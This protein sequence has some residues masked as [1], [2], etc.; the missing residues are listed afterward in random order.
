ML[1]RHVMLALP[2]IESVP[3]HVLDRVGRITRG[4]G[5][6]LELFH[7]VHNS[8]LTGRAMPGAA[9]DDLVRVRMEE[10]HRRLE[11]IADTLRDQQIDVHASVRAD[12]PV[13][14]AIIRQVLHHGSNLLIVP[15][16]RLGHAG[17]SR[18]LTYTDSRLIE[19]CPCPL[20][21]LK[22]NQAYA[23]GPIVAA[24]DPSHAHDKPAALDESIIA[25]A[26][27]LSSALSQAP[28][29]LYHAVP[30]LTEPAMRPGNGE[31]SEAPLSAERQKVHWVGREH[32]VRKLA[33]RHQLSERS[34]YVELGRI[35]A[36][37][38]TYSREVRA[39]AVVMGAISRSYPQRVLFGYTAEKVLDALDSDV[40]IVKPKG[41]RSPVHRRP[42]PTPQRA[43][44]QG[45]GALRHMAEREE[46]AT[47]WGWRR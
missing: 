21:L 34:V 39:D 12:Y 30:P 42:A 22:S 41:F 10:R 16:G 33:A 35:E 47:R 4:L 44:E 2:E 15:A 11:R 31:L 40:L 9:L 6:E 20:L 38:P 27:T 28:V 32:E 3:N 1:W 14:E 45:F 26:M 7:C 43:A 17:G 29:H 8:D 18:A 24:V 19:A 13:Y 36:T 37:L 5:A 25:A 46:G 23:Q